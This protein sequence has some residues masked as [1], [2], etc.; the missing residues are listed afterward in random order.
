VIP[1]TQRS[2]ALALAGGC[3]LWAGL[4]LGRSERMAI[5]IGSTPSE[6]RALGIRDL[7]SGLLLVASP[8]ARLPIALRVAFDVSDAAR[9]GRGRPAVLAMTLGF[10]GLGVAGLLAGRG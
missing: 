5:L 7:G 8:D 6:V 2:W 9:Y 3:A 10:A 4:A 1:V